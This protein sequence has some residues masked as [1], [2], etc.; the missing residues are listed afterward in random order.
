M[1]QLAGLV[2]ERWQKF[3]DAPAEEKA[4]VFSEGHEAAFELGREHTHAQ[5]QDFAEKVTLLFEKIAT[6]EGMVRTL[7]ERLNERLVA[8]GATPIATEIPLTITVPKIES[9][10][11]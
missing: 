7:T 10:D 8:E 2:E 9:I 3:N 4:D 11:P 1:R 5:Y 6:L